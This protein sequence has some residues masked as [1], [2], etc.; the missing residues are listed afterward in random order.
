MPFLLIVKKNYYILEMWE[1]MKSKIQKTKV[2]IMTK[3]SVI[4]SSSFFLYSYKTNNI[5]IGI[6][7][8]I[9]FFPTLLYDH[10]SNSLKIL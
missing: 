7:F 4:I 9:L 6:Y 10:S 8:Y 3:L 5:I 2:P 1:K